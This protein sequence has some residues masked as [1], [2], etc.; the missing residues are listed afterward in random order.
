MRLP[1]DGG[2]NCV[3]H[4]L[5]H[6]IGFF[7]EHVR[8]DR[9]SHIQ[10]QWHKIKRKLSYHTFNLNN[11]MGKYNVAT[12]KYNWSIYKGGRTFGEP[13]N[14]YSIMHYAPTGKNLFSFVEVLPFMA[15]I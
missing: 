15:M 8:V 12:Q 9:D 11:L 3:L 1:K 13:Y 2:P 6:A 10:I 14:V 7:H 5:I 4:E